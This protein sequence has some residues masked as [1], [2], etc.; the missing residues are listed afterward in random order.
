MATPDGKSTAD[1]FPV[2]FPTT[3]E[4]L[5]ISP[6]SVVAAYSGCVSGPFPERDIYGVFCCVIIVRVTVS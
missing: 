5:P 6:F 3:G 4:P 2:R 1:S